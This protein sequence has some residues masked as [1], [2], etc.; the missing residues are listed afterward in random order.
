M[1]ER[2]STTIGLV[3]AARQPAP[4]TFAWLSGCTGSHA[5][6]NSQASRD[7]PLLWR[8]FEVGCA[9]QLKQTIA[10][11]VSLN[12][13]CQSIEGRLDFG[14]VGETG[15]LTCNTTQ[16][17]IALSVLGK[18]PVNVAPGDSARAV[19]RAF[20]ASVGEMQKR[21][22]APRAGRASDMHLVSLEWRAP[23]GALAEDIDEHLVA[24]KH[25]LDIEQTKSRNGAGR[26]LEPVRIRDL[27]AKHL[28]TATNSEHMT[29]ATRMRLEVDVP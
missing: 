6:F 3:M 20:L 24:L 11:D 19:D 17:V 5:Q 12:V 23:I 4:E 8:F 9:C 7:S 1:T 14:F 29:A 22:Y 18:K 21:F 26:S 10:V 13:V 15:R 16:P 25:C 28:I 2:R 27:R